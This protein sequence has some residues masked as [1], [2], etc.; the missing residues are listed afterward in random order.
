MTPFELPQIDPIAFSVGPFSIR[1][2]A[3]AY[4]VGFLLAW[5]YCVW[6][7][8]GPTK[9]AGVDANA[10]LRAITPT[11]VGDLVTWA[12]IGVIVGGRLGYVFFYGFDSFIQHPLNIFK[13]WQGGMSF[14]GGMFGVIVT[15]T[16]FARARQV[17]LL[18][19]GDLVAAAAPIGL[20]LGRLG[21]FANGELYGRFTE[22]V[23]GVVFPS[24]PLQVPRHPSQLYEAVMEG[25]ILFLILHI[26]V[27]SSISKTHPGM[28]AG[29]FLVGYGCARFFVEFYRQPDAHLGL[30]A[31]ELSM[32]QWLCLPMI[33]G[34]IFLMI[35]SVR[36]RGIKK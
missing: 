26:T 34:G 24:D 33:A 35:F 36:N 25:L 3:L 29:L 20:C 31:F 14:H 23:V 16:I 1:W 10:N 15:V 8:N 9:G 18:A 5:R 7:V 12:I 30:L 6:M 4:V 21:N 2:Y 32:G 19:I 28:V 11:D 13:I 22:S 17:S 27:R